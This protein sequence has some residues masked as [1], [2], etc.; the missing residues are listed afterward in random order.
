MYFPF[1]GF[2]NGVCVKDCSP[3]LLPTQVHVPSLTPARC[4]EACQERFFSFAGVQAGRQCFC[5]NT[6]PPQEKILD[7]TECS[8]NCP[9]DSSLKCGGS[10]RMGVFKTTGRIRI[11]SLVSPCS[12]SL[13]RIPLCCPPSRVR[14]RP[15][16]FPSRRLQLCRTGGL[17]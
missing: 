12:P 1:S 4:I 6:A 15:L 7:V 2:W 11:W 17:P 16:G 13:C 14:G 10:C 3:R 9:G 5:G 8:A